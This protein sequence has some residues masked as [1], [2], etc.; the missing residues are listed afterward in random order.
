MK[1]IFKLKFLVFV[2]IALVV[3]ITTTTIVF[4]D[5]VKTLKIG[6]AGDIT[7]FLSQALF[8]DGSYDANY[9]VTILPTSLSNRGG[10][11][12]SATSSS[13]AA[14]YFSN[15]NG[16]GLLVNQGNVGIGTTVPLSK[17]S[18]Q[19]TAGSANIFTIASS[20]GANLLTVTKDGNVG[21]GTT[22]PNSLLHLYKNISGTNAEI[23]IQSGNG[24]TVQDKWAIY[25]DQVAGGLRFWNNNINAL[26]ILKNGNVGIGTTTPG[27]KL[28]ISDTENAAM[29]RLENKNALRKYTG[30]RLDR[31]G[32]AEKWFIG[33][34]DGDDKLRIRATGTT[35]VLTIDSSTGNVGIGTTTPSQKLEIN[36]IAKMTGFQLGNSATTGQVLTTNASGVGTWQSSAGTSFANPT[37]SIV[38][39]AVNGSAATAMRSDAAPALSQSIIPT[40][41]STHTFSNSSYSALFTGGDVGIGTT[42]PSQKL[43]V[44]GGNINTSGNLLASGMLTVSGAGNSSISGNVG[45]GTTM[46]SAKLTVVADANTGAGNEFQIC[47]NG[48][49]CPIW[50]DCDLDGKTWGSGDCD[51][52][53]STCYFGS[54][55]YTAA[56]DG[57][58]QNCNGFVDEGCGEPERTIRNSASGLSC[59]ARCEPTGQTCKKIY[60]STGDNSYWGEWGNPYCGNT[61]GTCSTV[62]SN[63]GR[64]CWLSVSEWSD[65]VCNSVNNQCR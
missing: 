16:Y 44:Q 42:E 51:E 52:S 45:I 55:A 4:A 29:I 61:V 1:K 2:L 18:I 49:C 28:D 36:G 30:L 38:L 41:T 26:T 24:T 35:D 8:G 40:W 64:E 15:A 46:P 31:N 22:T 14:G 19:G 20:T 54:T 48:T 33:M 25:Q 12:V 32:L 60:I 65:C 27:Y 6:K 3:L 57:K 63:V 58:D 34:N 62:M 56:P 23:A 11:I 59:T 21:I 13:A 50:K 47:K 43:D 53:C 17:L 10:I 9:Q 39:T 5:A 37:A 7:W